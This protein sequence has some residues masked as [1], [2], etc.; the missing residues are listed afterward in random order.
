MHF[1]W[2]NKKDLSIIKYEKNESMY[3]DRPSWWKYLE[4]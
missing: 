2:Q 1:V 4:T 3:V